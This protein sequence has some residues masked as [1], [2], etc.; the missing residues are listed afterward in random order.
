MVHELEVQDVR[1]LVLSP[2]GSRFDIQ[3]RRAD[4]KDS[5]I[6]FPSEALKSLLMSLF[7]VADIV[8]R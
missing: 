6:V 3:V 5:A 2:D 7:R 4:G 1:N 8:L